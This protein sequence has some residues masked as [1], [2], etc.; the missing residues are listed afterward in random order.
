M[1][2]PCLVCCRGPAFAA[3]R[4]T[5]A[6]DGDNGD[7]DDDDDGGDGGDDGDGF[8][9]SGGTMSYAAICCRSAPP[10]FHNM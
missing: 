8:D 7:N 9:A 2:V 1:V 6:A 4:A 5:A 3:A 10:R